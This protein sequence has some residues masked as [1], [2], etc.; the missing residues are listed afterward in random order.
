MAHSRL[1][2]RKVASY[3]ANELIVGNNVVDKLASYLL[4]TKQVGEL[5]LYVR[6]IESAL[7]ERGILIADVSSSYQLEKE[8]EEKLTDYLKKESKAKEVH[9]RQHLDSNV[10]GG[11]RIETPDERLDSTLRHRINQLT[12]SKI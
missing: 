7:S 1:S 4:E 2:R 9:L 11:I 5:S 3:L 10:L 12:T 8:T 6:D